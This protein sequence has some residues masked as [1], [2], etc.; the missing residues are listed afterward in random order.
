MDEVEFNIRS[1]FISS[2][3]FTTQT[4]ITNNSLSLSIFRARWTVLWVVLSSLSLTFY[5][6]LPLSVS[7]CKS[8]RLLNSSLYSACSKFIF[9]FPGIKNLFIT[10]LKFR[11]DTCP[12]LSI[13]KRSNVIR[14]HL[15]RSLKVYS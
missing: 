6:L 10:C 9:P 11:L 8:S 4:R 14:G 2:I 7:T 12:T 13:S 5:F 15:S 1:N 3:I